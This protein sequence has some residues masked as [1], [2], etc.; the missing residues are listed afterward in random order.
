M[1]PSHDQGIPYVDYQF[2]QISIDQGFDY[3]SDTASIYGEFKPNPL[4]KILESVSVGASIISVD[5]TIDF[6]EYGN[7]AINDVDGQE[8]SIGYSGKTSNQFF[9]CDGIIKDIDKTED[10][11]LDDYS[12]AYVGINTDTEIQVRFTSTLKDFVQNEKT[13]YFR[14]LD[15]IQVKSLGYEATTKKNNNWFLN[16]KPKYRVGDTTVIDPLAFIYQFKFLETHFFSEGYELRYENPD[17]NISTD[18]DWETNYY[19]FWL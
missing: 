18:R 7:L 9:N 10:V 12:Y 11:K 1:F 3:T 8:M 4:T 16:I 19:S 15:T 5:S 2:Y 13:N 6:P 14:P 17:Q